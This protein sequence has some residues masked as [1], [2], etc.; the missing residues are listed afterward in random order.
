MQK[1]IYI[2]S[3]TSQLAL[4]M[5]NQVIEELK[6][7]SSTTNVEIIKITTSNA[8][9][10]N[11]P[12]GI[13]G[14]FTNALDD[15]VRQGQASFGVHSTKDLPSKL[16]DDMVVAAYLKRGNPKDAIISKHNLS[17]KKL[18]KN[19]VIGTASLRR[20]MLVKH[21]RPD[22]SIAPLR[23]NIDTRLNKNTDYDAIILAACGLERF[24]A[25][26]HITE[27]LD[28]TIFI[29]A[30]GQGAIAITCRRN[31][32]ETI[33]LLRPLDHLE[34]RKCVEIERM[35]CAQLNLSCHAPI[36][37]YTYYENNIIHTKIHLIRNNQSFI[38]SF[39]CT[40]ADIDTLVVKITKE[41]LDKTS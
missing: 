10:Q 24:D 15:A 13:K 2:A 34:T 22:L 35:I 7:Y 21:I 18:P 30:A 38:Q 23:G 25:K 33:A 31:D 8:N 32:T 29:P 20:A 40:E 37:V 4:I 6:Q 9:I 5:T 36:G 26:K 41:I 28:P 12:L 11:E 14:V 1:K 19:A 3:R 39:S 17:L 27:Q 16:S